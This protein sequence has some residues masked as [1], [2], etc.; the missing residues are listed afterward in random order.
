MYIICWEDGTWSGF[1]LSEI[2]AVKFAQEGRYKITSNKDGVVKRVLMSYVVESESNRPL[3]SQ[4]PL[5][6]VI[7]YKGG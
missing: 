1:Y 5:G 2:F 7:S 3:S 4:V 6:E